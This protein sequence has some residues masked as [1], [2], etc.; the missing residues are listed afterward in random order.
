[1]KQLSFTGGNISGLWFFVLV[2]WVFFNL[3]QNGLAEVTL[4]NKTAKTSYCV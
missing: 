1:M 3:Y 2:V 4:A